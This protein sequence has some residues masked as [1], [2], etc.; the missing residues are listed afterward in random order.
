ML[1]IMIFAVIGMFLVPNPAVASGIAFNYNGAD[2]V[3][4]SCATNRVCILLTI[5]PAKLIEC[6]GER[7]VKWRKVYTR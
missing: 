2:Y 3:K 5:V 6:V 7:R 1:V 4:L